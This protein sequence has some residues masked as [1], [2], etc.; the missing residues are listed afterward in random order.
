MAFQGRAAL[1]AVDVQ[2]GIL[3][4]VPGEVSADLV[5]KTSALA[6]AF[7]AAD[8]PVVW[9]HATGLPAGVTERPIPEP[10]ELPDHFSELDPRLPVHDGDIHVNKPRT[11]SAFV[12]TGLA[13]KLRELGVSDVV[14][15]G[16]ATGAGVESTARSAY[17]EGFHITAAVDAMVDGNPARHEQ[18]IAEDFP[19]IGIVSTTADI[20]AGLSED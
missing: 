11:W 8:L 16:I 19:S 20:V 6:D 15:L 9:V 1:I 12:G 4:M 7:H 5:A 14:V 18:A 17:D 13:E 3:G 2:Q 10:D